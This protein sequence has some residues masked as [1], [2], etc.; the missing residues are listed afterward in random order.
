VAI[1]RTRRI[2]AVVVAVVGCRDEPEPAPSLAEWAL[3][4]TLAA[5]CP[6]TVTATDEC[7]CRGVNA[8]AQ[9][10]LGGSECENAIDYWLHDSLS[11]GLTYDGECAAAV[12]ERNSDYVD[13]EQLSCSI[14]PPS[15]PLVACE[16]ECQIYFGDAALG[17]ACTRFGP[18]MST[19]EAD[20]VCGVDGTCHAPCERPLEIPKGGRC[21]QFL[22]ALVDEAC[23]EGTVCSPETSTCEVPL[24]L[25]ETCDHSTAPCPK[26]HY[27]GGP[28]YVCRPR[29]AL[30]EPCDRHFD[31]LS[32]V[33]IDDV[34]AAPDPWSCDNRWF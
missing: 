32:Y 22:G 6:G 11:V 13:S 20:L 18:R 14:D 19:C 10:N 30:G 8:M 34:C 21:S 27:C 28:E 29:G 25:G 12:L 17:D 5:T 15:E 33:C 3:E 1:V 2:L 26:D 16:D 24:A 9:T 23:I 7:P 4:G 31:C